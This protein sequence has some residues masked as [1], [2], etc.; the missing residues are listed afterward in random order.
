MVHPPAV[1]SAFVVLALYPVSH[2]ILHCVPTVTGGTQSLKVIPLSGSAH[3]G[4]TVA[5]IASNGSGQSTGELLVKV[6][7]ATAAGLLF[8]F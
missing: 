5:A 7:A 6:S 8:P 4:V 1:H 3:V 2:S